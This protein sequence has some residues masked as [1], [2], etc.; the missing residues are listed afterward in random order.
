MKVLVT[1][2]SGQ[3]G[4]ALRNCAPG[5]GVDVAALGRADLDLTDAGAICRTIERLQPAAVINA[6]A[7]TAVDRAESEPE[8]A[9]AVNSDA[10]SALAYVCAKERVRL[11]HVST[12]F[13]F[14]GALG[15]PYLPGDVTNPLSVYGASKLAGERHV[16]GQSGLDWRIVRT[17][18]VY[19]ASGQNFMLTMLRLFRERSVVKI[20]ADQI[21][22]PTSAASLAE[23]LWRVAREDGKSDISHF[24]DAGVAS[25]YDFAV[26]IH[27]EARALGIINRDVDVVPIATDQYPTAARRPLYSVL[28]KRA[29]IERF[30]LH[31]VH[32]RVRLR[33]TL[34]ELGS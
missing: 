20:V 15:R 24:T 26:A 28:E 23:H 19:S 32:W 22:T 17:A 2:A 29:T 25:W 14:D 34:Q 9:Y 21:G 8:L 7:Y 4:R 1:G 27:E 12:D 5:A 3:L 30:A 13:V 31:P 6:A 11:V 10:V 33:K 16:L 18:W